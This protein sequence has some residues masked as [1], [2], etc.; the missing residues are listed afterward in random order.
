MLCAGSTDPFIAG[1]FAPFVDTGGGS[2]RS[3]SVARQFSDSLGT[4][5]AQ[6]RQCETQFVRCIRPNTSLVPIS[7]FD[8][9]LVR[10]ACGAVLNAGSCWEPL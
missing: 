7:L 2:R 3:A 4:L 5:L 9:V 1:L 10:H 6:M 8:N